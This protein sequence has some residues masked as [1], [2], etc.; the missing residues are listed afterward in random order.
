MLAKAAILCG[1][2][3]RRLRPLTESFQKT[4]VPVGPRNRPVLEYTVRLMVYHGIRDIT[5]LTGYRS[6]QVEEYFRKGERFGARIT[7]S[8]D[9]N[10]VTGTAHSLLNAC[11]NGSIGDFDNIIVY[12]GDV[13]S[14][15]DVK[16]LLEQ[17]ERE[18][19]SVTLVLSHDY[20]VPVGVAR[21]R[22]GRVVSFEEKPILGLRTLVGGMAISSGCIPTLK[23]VAS[24]RGSCDI[25]THFLP[26]VIRSSK[27]VAPFDI[28]GFWYDIG[29]M[30]TFGKLDS[31]QLEKN[32]GFLG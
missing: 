11:R 4:M 3:G 20:Q 26:E 15:L 32:L 22:R 23:N 21:V 28:S 5:L 10:D 8:R 1:G 31:E 16:S 24:R 6:E 12:F 30:E 7:F 17:H 25:M 2:E 13:I 18:R 29:T 9:P 14:A 27:K 19:A